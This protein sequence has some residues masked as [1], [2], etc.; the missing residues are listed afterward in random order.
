MGTPGH[1]WPWR[2]LSAAPTTRR[3]RRREGLVA[4]AEATDKPALRFRR[5]SSPKA[6]PTETSIPATATGG[7]PA[8]VERSLGRAATGSANRTSP[9]HCRELE[10]H[11]GAQ[12]IRVRP[13]HA[14]DA[15]L[16]RL[17][18]H[19]DCTQSAGHPRRVVGS[20]RPLRICRHYRRLRRQSL[21]RRTGFPEINTAITHL[22]EVLGDKGYES[23]AR[24]GENMT[25]A[26]MATYAFEQIDRAR[27]QLTPTGGAQ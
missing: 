22:R 7:P 17:G 10:V 1:P 9:S 12:R 27:A 18:Q 24:A 16:P 13:P 14:G 21:R 8:G 5:H 6:W 3:W 11:H 26:A 15:Q 25:N 19:R 2:W 23:L 4:V 20:T